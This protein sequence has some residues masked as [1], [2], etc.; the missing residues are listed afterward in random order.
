MLE[1]ARWGPRFRRGEKRALRIVYDIEDQVSEYILALIAIN[2]VLGTVIGVAFHL[3]GMPAPYLWGLL[4]FFLNFIPYIGANSAA[5]LSGFMA[6]ITFDSIGYALLVPAVFVGLSL[7]ESELASPLILGRRLQMNSV[8]ILL[9]LAFWTWL[10][11]VP[12]TILAVP[13]LVVLKVLCD[14]L[15]GLSGLGEFLSVRRAG[16]PIETEPG[17]T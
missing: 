5:V 14:H 8:A 17:H 13:L 10:W 16:A 6:V 1:N 3:L 15:D 4:T 9:S 2:A 12:G 7:I 11:G